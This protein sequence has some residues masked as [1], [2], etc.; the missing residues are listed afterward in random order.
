MTNTLM[1]VTWSQVTAFRL[2]RHHLAERA[3]VKDL[4]AVVHEMAGAQAQ[5]FPAAQISLWSRVRDLQIAHI[6]EALSQRR[7]V[8]A[9]C[10]R[11]TLFLVPAAHL[12]VLARGAARR[13]EKEITWAR[14]KGVPA[15]TIEAAIEA[16][17]SVLDQ[18][19]TRPEIADRVSRALK[20][21]R[22][23]VHGG[24]WAS[25]SKV[26]AVPIGHLIYPVVDLVHLAAARGVICYGPARENEPTFVRADA[27]LPRWRDLPGERADSLLLQCY[28]HAY[29]PA[30]AVDFAMWSGFT[31]TEA[32]EVWTRE[33]ANLAPV[34]IAGEEAAV[35]QT[36]LAELT[37]AHLEHPLV[38]LL[39]YFDS[40]LLGHKART[41][42][43]PAQRHTQVYRAQ[44]WIAPTVLVDGHVAGVWAHTRLGDRLN[45]NVTTFEALSRRTLANLRAEAAD[46]GH[47]LGILQVNVQIE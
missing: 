41:H 39:P 44:G 7:L 31:L 16:T 15:R 37:Q 17:L 24:G 13:A 26:A 43:V 18:P 3:P 27:W 47:F 2:G 20:V 33:A 12:A 10:M 40:Y 25:R 35:W 23:H 32:R 14:K 45:I 29:G 9:S 1:P 8:K 30:T 34:N 21:S 5:L 4:L 42:L 19:L 36:D 11:R 38:R 28:L 6:D 22:Q 46:L